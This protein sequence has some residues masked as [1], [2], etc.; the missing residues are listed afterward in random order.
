[1]PI[2]E[3]LH[4]LG[5]YVRDKYRVVAESE[6]NYSMNAVMRRVPIPVTFVRKSE[7]TRLMCSHNVRASIE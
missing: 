4:L 7:D 3:R 6:L 1:M 5:N 2:L